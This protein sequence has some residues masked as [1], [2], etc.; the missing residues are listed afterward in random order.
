MLLKSETFDLL[1]HWQYVYLSSKLQ[2][3]WF[4]NRTII[5]QFPLQTTLAFH[6]KITKLPSHLKTTLE[7]WT[8]FQMFIGS[9]ILKFF[10]IHQVTRGLLSCVVFEGCLRIVNVTSPYAHKTFPSLEILISSFHFLIRFFSTYIFPFSNSNKK[11]LETMQTHFCLNNLSGRF[12]IFIFEKLLE[13]DVLNY[14]EIL[15]TLVG[16]AECLI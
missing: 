6:L 9:L 11:P 12:S 13:K 5:Y 8:L 14:I 16:V 3:S 4:L 15:C 1:L 7:S 2:L 10:G